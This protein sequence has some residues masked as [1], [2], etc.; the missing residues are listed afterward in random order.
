MLDTYTIANS[1][2]QRLRSLTHDAIDATN[3]EITN[4]TNRLNVPTLIIVSHTRL[5]KCT[6]VNFFVQ[7][8]T[9]LYIGLP[10]SAVV[11]AWNI[12]IINSTVYMFQAVVTVWYICIYLN[13]VI[14]CYFSKKLRTLKLCITNLAFHIIR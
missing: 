3:D 2:F 1:L 13:S 9:F 4:I 10:H 8:V 11:Y 5:S 12:L 7:W 6:K 14:I